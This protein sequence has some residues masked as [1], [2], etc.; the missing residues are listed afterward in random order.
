ML[1]LS[2][3]AWYPPQNQDGQPE[4]RGTGWPSGV[5]IDGARCPGL[6]LPGLTLP[7][8]TL[9][10]LVLPGLVLPGLIRRA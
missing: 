4:L 10:G 8:L 3:R 5:F 7:G 6:I 2:G 9:P 1:A